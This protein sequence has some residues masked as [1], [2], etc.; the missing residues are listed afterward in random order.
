MAGLCTGS[1]KS[2]LETGKAEPAKQSKIS[3]SLILSGKSLQEGGEHIS[4]LC[5]QRHETASVC[6][7]RVI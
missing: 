2:Q 1:G 5:V 3:T 6:G 4:E 7:R